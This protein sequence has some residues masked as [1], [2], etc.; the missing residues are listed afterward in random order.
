MNQSLILIAAG[1]VVLAVFALVF[2]VPSYR[3][4]AK[5]DLEIGK[6][7]FKIET[8]EKLGP[9]YKGLEEK[10]KRIDRQATLSPLQPIPKSQLSS[11]NGA[12]SGIALR[13]KLSLL[14]VY[15]ETLSTDAGSTV[16]NVNLRG[17]FS[18]FRN[19]LKEVGKLTYV[20]SVQEIQINTGKGS[21]EFNIKIKLLVA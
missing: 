20:D 19:F 9:L 12:I 10:L 1:I 21:R 4:I 15:P 17:N 18:D 16:Y 13:S 14:S 7:K 2:I 6:A 3:D 5:L 11:F 8:Q